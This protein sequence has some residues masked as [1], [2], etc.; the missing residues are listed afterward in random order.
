MW[1][2]VEVC[3]CGGGKGGGGGNGDR[4]DGVI[5]GYACWHDCFEVVV[6]RGFL[7]K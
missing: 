4:K 7:G 5:V 6:I 2:Q 1:T 3:S